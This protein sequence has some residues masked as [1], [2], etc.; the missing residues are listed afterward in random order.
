MDRIKL[1]ILMLLGL[2][3]TIFPDSL[4]S[5]VLIFIGLYTTYIGVLALISTLQLVRYRRGWQIE[6]VRAA[7]FLLLG[8]VLLFNTQVIAITISGIFFV[9]LG[10]MILSLGITAVIRSREYQVGSVIIVVGLLITLF[11]IGISHLIT[12]VI[13]MILLITSLSMLLKIRSS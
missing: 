3:I 7:S 8:L 4:I 9:L 12:R 1:Y 13:G 2:L 5:I 6:G 11:P 10:L